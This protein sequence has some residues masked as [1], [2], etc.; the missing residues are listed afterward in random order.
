MPNPD[1]LARYAEIHL[2]EVTGVRLT[3]Y[4][5]YQLMRRG[6]RPW[7][8]PKGGLDYLYPT[9]STAGFQVYALVDRSLKGKPVATIEFTLG[10]CGVAHPKL[11]DRGFVFIEHGRGYAAT[12]WESD[13]EAF[14]EAAKALGVEIESES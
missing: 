10:G 2:V 5:A 3:E 14:N 1:D 4:E 7:P 6:A 8:E 13:G 11:H 12:I 9:S